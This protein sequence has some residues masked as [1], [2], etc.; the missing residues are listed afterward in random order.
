MRLGFLER[1]LQEHVVCV[2]MITLLLPQCCKHFFRNR[3]KQQKLRSGISSEPPWQTR[4]RVNRQLPE[5]QQNKAS[6]KVRDG[7][8]PHGWHGWQGHHDLTAKV[9][10]HQGLELKPN[11]ARSWHHTQVSQWCS[12]LNQISESEVFMM[13]GHYLVI[14]GASNTRHG[15][16]GMECLV[17]DQQSFDPQQWDG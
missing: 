1:L 11:Y 17:F 10:Y 2:Q 4:A 9:A 12:S 16:H 13:F 14:C 15:R 7:R 3:S 8:H 5:P 6:H